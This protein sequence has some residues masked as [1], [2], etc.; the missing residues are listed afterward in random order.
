MQESLSVIADRTR[1]CR[2]KSKGYGDY[3]EGV[4]PIEIDDDTFV[5]MNVAIKTNSPRV[6]L[7][8]FSE[9]SSINKNGISPIGMTIIRKKEDGFYY[10]TQYDFAIA[11]INGGKEELIEI[12]NEMKNNDARAIF[13][14]LRDM[15][16]VYRFWNDAWYI[17]ERTYERGSEDCGS[18]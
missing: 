10:F 2:S 17:K 13:N 1:I 15:Q 16:D 7:N 9:H 5:Y 18:C 11:A 12:L 8:S 4:L 6:P 3:G 14:D